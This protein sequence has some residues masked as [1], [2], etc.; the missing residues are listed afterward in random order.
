MVLSESRLD[1]DTDEGMRVATRV[2]RVRPNATEEEEEEE[3]EE[4]SAC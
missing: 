3:E 1:P 2:G 4:I